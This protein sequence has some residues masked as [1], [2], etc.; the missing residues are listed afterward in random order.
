MATVAPQ[1]LRPAFCNLK[2][3][4]V[5]QLYKAACLFL[6]PSLLSRWSLHQSVQA[7]LRSPYVLGR[8]FDIALKY[9][10]STL[11]I[12]V[13]LECCHCYKK[14]RKVLC[15]L[16][17]LKRKLLCM[18]CDVITGI[19]IVPPPKPPDKPPTPPRRRRRSRVRRRW[20]VFFRRGRASHRHC[21]RHHHR[22]R[23]RPR[24]RHRHRHRHLLPLR[25]RRVR[26]RGAAGSRARARARRRAPITEEESDATSAARAGRKTADRGP[27]TAAAA[28]AVLAAVPGAARSSPRPAAATVAVLAAVPGAPAA[29]A[30]SSA[31]KTLGPSAP[32]CDPT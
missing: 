19:E 18:A 13:D 1:W 10:I 8:T 31:R 28:V 20:C 22:H 12:K 26:G 16:Q 9:K 21:A 25:R 15:K 3:F 6:F 17:G 23:H 27:R 2:D 7:M 32:P 29:A 14:I 5:Q 11:I 24:H 30:R 4:E